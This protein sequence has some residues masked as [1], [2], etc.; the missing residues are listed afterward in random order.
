MPQSGLRFMSLPIVA[1]CALLSACASPSSSTAGQ[2]AGQMSGEARERIAEAAEA[3]GDD[4]L[5]LSMY[6]AASADAP[7]NSKFRLRYADILLRSGK[8]GPARDLLTQGLATASDPV[9]IRRGL[10][11][12][13]VLSGQSGQAIAE[14]DK[15]LAAHPNDLR[16]LVDKAI[17][18]DLQGNHSEAQRLYLQ[19]RQ[20]APDDPVI[21]NDLALSLALQGRVTEARDLLMPFKDTGNAP[22]R[23]KVTLRILSAAVGEQEQSSPAVGAEVADD[24]IRR[25][26]MEFASTARTG[27]GV[28]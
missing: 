28:R 21:A 1:A 16:A 20:G 13:H 7:A 25:I 6:A 18:L 12:I 27:T 2:K 9:E 11:A 10:G 22:E 15:V 19:A 26:A 14:F 3:S 5:A 23:L 17:A 4:E 8:I 24:A